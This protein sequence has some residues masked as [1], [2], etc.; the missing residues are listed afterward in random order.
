MLVPLAALA[1]AAALASPALAGGQATTP[2]THK[3]SHSTAHAAL[4][5]LN[6]ADE[7]QLA[8]LPGVGETYAKQIIAGRP[9]K[10]KDELVNRKIVPKATFEKFHDKVIAKQAPA[11]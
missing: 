3:K 1:F 2:G 9:Y 4:V 5:D 8:A 7:A 11:K 6:A 10:S